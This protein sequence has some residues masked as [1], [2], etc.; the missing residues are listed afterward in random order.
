[1]S[2]ARAIT[3]A[4]LPMQSKGHWGFDPQASFWIAFKEV[5]EKPATPHWPEPVY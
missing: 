2:G 4:F 3:E 1:M 5:Q